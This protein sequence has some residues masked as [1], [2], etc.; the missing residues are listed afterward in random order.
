[1][2]LHA[3]KPSDW[4]FILNRLYTSQSVL[5]IECVFV[6]QQQQQTWH[7]NDINTKT[8]TPREQNERGH[9]F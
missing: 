8:Q 4:V 2:D 3:I 6:N 9:E 1:M 7:F 5:E